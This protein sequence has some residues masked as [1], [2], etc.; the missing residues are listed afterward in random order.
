M[1]EIE[2]VGNLESQNLDIRNC[3]QYNDI[4][5]YCIG[6]V[7]N[8]S[9]QG[10]ESRDGRDDTIQYKLPMIPFQDISF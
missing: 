5:K 9:I 3:L 4:E 7:Q 1:G 10:W 2:K 8:F 6:F